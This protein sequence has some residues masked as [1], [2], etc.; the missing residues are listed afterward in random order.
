[1]KTEDNYY[2]LLLSFLFTYDK[3]T[4]SEMTDQECEHECITYWDIRRL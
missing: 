3:K 4:L 2:R 1:M